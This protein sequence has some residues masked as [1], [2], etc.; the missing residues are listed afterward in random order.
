MKPHIKFRWL[1]WLSFLIPAVL[2]VASSIRLTTDMKQ[3]LPNTDSQLMSAINSGPNSRLILL[4]LS[5]GTQK[6]LSRLNQQLATAFR[7]STYFSQVINGSD[8][9][10]EK[11]LDFLFKHRYL[12]SPST[13]DD[14][15]SKSIRRELEIRLKELSESFSLFP[16]KYLQPDPTGLTI[17]LS[18]K[19]NRQTGNLT[20]I[21]N[22]LFSVNKERSLIFLWIKHSAGNIGGQEETIEYI[23]SNFKRLNNSNITM[24]I[25]GLPYIAVTSKE[26]IGSESKRLSLLGSLFIFILI[27]T[28]YRSFRIALLIAAPLASGILV[29]TLAVLLLYGEIHGIT[30]AFGI[31]L[32]GISI[33][34]PIHVFTHNSGDK[35]KIEAVWKTIYIGMITT[36]IGFT[37]LTFS[38]LV[39]LQQLGVFACSGILAAV[40]SSRLLLSQLKTGDIDSRIQSFSTTVFKQLSR[41]K[42]STVYLIIIALSSTLFISLNSD[43][44]FT[45]DLQSLT[46]NQSTKPHELTTADTGRLF[47]IKTKSIESVLQISE[48]ITKQLDRWVSEGLLIAYDAPSNYIPSISQQKKNLSVLPE[49]K[50]LHQLIW[51]ANRGLPFKDDTFTPFVDAVTAA[52]NTDPLELGD[53]KQTGLYTRIEQR[54]YK[55]SDHWIGVINLSGIT[56]EQRIFEVANRHTPY[57]S[58]VNVSADSADAVHYYHQE[59]ML[60]FLLGLALIAIILT[61]RFGLKFAGITLLPIISAILFTV[62]MLVLLGHSLT[63]FHTASLLLVLGLG[64]DYSLFSQRVE[65]GNITSTATALF[66]CSFS[67]FTIFALLASSTVVALNAIGTTVFMGAFS[68]YIFSLSAARTNLPTG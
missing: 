33:D 62:V 17:A 50:R 1:I 60:L 9:N 31:T 41:I 42:N 61:L 4:T 14:F 53:F 67:T 52:K 32:L 45:S 8:N 49:S 20:L 21:N 3:F 63:I 36:I 59:M 12:L 37:S 48:S 51:T 7:E 16:R 39:G 23:G 56:D 55:E 46:D 29:G 64:L 57:V 26:K 18:N 22:T 24:Q 44:F 58:Y 11:I 43:N 65:R 38:S 68:A 5:N 40:L 47:I 15:S 6:S 2:Y 54:L 10:N 34:Y 28:I 25:D 66:V 30:L 27:V 13:K 19:L 35:T